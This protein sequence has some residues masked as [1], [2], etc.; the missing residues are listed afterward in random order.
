MHYYNYKKELVQKNTDTKYIQNRSKNVK[1]TKINLIGLM[2]H[3]PVEFLE[4]G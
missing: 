4:H 2:A 1:K 3:D